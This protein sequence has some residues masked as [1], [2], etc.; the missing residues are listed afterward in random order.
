M[1]RVATSFCLC[2]WLLVLIL[3]RRKPA[4][5]SMLVQLIYDFRLSLFQSRVN[6]RSIN[7]RAAATTQE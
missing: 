7:L 1:F 4:H 5:R 2:F 3:I 6:G